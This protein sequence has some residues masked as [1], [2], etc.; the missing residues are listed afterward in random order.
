MVVVVVVV[1]GVF[2]NAVSI[3]SKTVGL[4]NDGL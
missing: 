2:S 4:S 3:C 1:R